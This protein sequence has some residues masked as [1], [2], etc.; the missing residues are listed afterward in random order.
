MTHT[1][2]ANQIMAHAGYCGAISALGTA[3][4]AAMNA[5]IY[6]ISGSPAW[7]SAGPLVGTARLR[8]KLSAVSFQRGSAAEARSKGSETGCGD[9]RRLGIVDILQRAGSSGGSTAER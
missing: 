9:G 4:L 6:Y 3:G 8:P 5:L 2:P 1:A 7:P